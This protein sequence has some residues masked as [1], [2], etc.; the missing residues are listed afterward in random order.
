MAATYYSAVDCHWNETPRM[1]RERERERERRRAG[2]GGHTA[3]ETVSDC[4][5][6]CV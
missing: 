2:E 5:R 4:V 1:H 3:A 6:Y